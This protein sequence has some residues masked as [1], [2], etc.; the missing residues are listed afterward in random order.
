MAEMSDAEFQRLLGRLMPLV[1][2]MITEAV[3]AATK[4]T[5]VM[6]AQAADI[7]DTDGA[8]ITLATSDDPSGAVPATRATTATQGQRCVVLF[9]PGG[10]AFAI[11]MIP[12]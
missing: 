1:N 10:G 4:R 9:V 12:T 3:R 5:P 2:A 11:G 8:E 6:T 7:I